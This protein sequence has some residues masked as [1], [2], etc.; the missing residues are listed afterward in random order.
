MARVVWWRLSRVVG[1]FG[2][3]FRQRA[4]HKKQD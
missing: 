4:H 1:R 2:P 3:S